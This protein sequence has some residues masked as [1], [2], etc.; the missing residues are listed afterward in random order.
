MCFL[1][2]RLG[3]VASGRLL[4]TSSVDLRPQIHADPSLFV[5]FISDDHD[6]RNHLDSSTHGAV[7]M[8]ALI[9]PK[10]SRVGSRQAPATPSSIACRP[11][12]ARVRGASNA[13]VGNSS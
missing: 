8:A 6:L 7:L 1:H 5:V 9:H 11:H 12:A 2:R 10:T 3:F 13:P 4:D